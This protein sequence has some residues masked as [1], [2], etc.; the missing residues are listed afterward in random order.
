MHATIISWCF[1]QFGQFGPANTIAQMI[2]NFVICLVDTCD[3]KSMYTLYT[4]S[5]I[6]SHHDDIVIWQQ[7]EKRDKKNALHTTLCAISARR[8]DHSAFLTL[9]LV[10][11]VCVCIWCVCMCVCVCLCL[12]VMRACGTCFAHCGDD[13]FI[14]HSLYYTCERCSPDNVIGGVALI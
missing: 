11:G 14:P 7:P 2:H 4:Y 5:Y 1:M 10:G 13:K 6:W 8:D 9:H 12:C 3:N